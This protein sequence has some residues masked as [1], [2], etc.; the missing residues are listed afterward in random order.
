MFL[1]GRFSLYTSYYDVFLIVGI[2]PIFIPFF[3]ELSLCLRC[4]FAYHTDKKAS[5]QVPSVVAEQI[6]PTCS[7]G[8]GKIMTVIIHFMSQIQTYSLVVCECFKCV[9]GSHSHSQLV[10]SLNLTVNITVNVLHIHNYYA[11]H[12]LFGYICCAPPIFETIFTVTTSFVWT[13]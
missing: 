5:M 13:P 11:M 10:L 1:G 9:T 8:Q 3:I 7:L 12:G 2:H 6:Y 4:L